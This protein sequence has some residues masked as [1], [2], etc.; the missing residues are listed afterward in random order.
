MAGN[1]NG[2]GKPGTLARLAF[3]PDST[4]MGFNE[5][6]GNGQAQPR[7]PLG[8]APGLIGPVKPFKDI[9]EIGSCDPRAGI[10]H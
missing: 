3:D 10:S 9:G 6:F 7:S 1:R 4:P 5:T 8:P 2:K